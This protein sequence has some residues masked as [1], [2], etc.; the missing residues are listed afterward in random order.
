MKITK[1]ELRK[2][3]REAKAG[4]I[5]GIG[6]S[7]WN[8]NRNPDFAKAYG[9]DAV[10]Y[11]GSLLR[12]QPISGE[13]AEEMSRSEASHYPRVDWDEVGDLV[14]KWADLELKSFDPGDPS[15]NPEDMTDADAKAIWGDQVESAMLDL[16]AELTQRIRK[17]ALAAMKEY[18]ER[19]MNGDYA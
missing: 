5:G 10:T 8:A 11:R 9:K 7:G 1:K 15:Q 3:I 4:S 16:E 13:Q 6:F 19:L 14:D 18:S 2:L 17:T 12:E